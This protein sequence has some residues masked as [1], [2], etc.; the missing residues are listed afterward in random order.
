MKCVSAIFLWYR[1]QSAFK[2]CYV[3]RIREWVKLDVTT[4]GH[5]VH[6]PLLKQ[7]LLEH[8]AQ[9]CVQMA[10]LKHKTRSFCNNNDEDLVILEKGQSQVLQLAKSII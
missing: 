10:L 1:K 8:M 7:A 3:H 4:G 9:D 5:L 6:P 2:E